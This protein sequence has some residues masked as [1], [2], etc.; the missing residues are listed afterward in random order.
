MSVLLVAVL[1]LGVPV[2]VLPDGLARSRWQALHA[3]MLCVVLIVAAIAGKGGWMAAA[4]AAVAALETAALLRDVERGAPVSLTER[5]PVP[6]GRSGPRRLVLAVLAVLAVLLL[7]PAPVPAAMRAAVGLLLLGLLGIVPGSAMP[8][9][10]VGGRLALRGVLLG[11]CL[12]PGHDP[13]LLAV[14]LTMVFAGAL[15]FRSRG[16]RGGDLAA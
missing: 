8:D 2:A 5:P 11:T 16:Q 6:P 12:L 15:S 10:P 4:G 9:A 1:L 13:V 3:A 7:P 14:V